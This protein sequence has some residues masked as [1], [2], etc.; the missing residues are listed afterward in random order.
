MNQV[1]VYTSAE[2]YAV[3]FARHGRELSVYSSYSAPDGESHGD[4][5]KCVMETEWCLRD[6]PLIGIRDEWRKGD[7]EKT[8]TSKYWLCLVK[9]ED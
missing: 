7:R 1:K 9:C 5:E 8:M 3:I 2:V 4:P 6:I